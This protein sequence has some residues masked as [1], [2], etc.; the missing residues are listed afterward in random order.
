MRM[1][2]PHLD[3]SPPLKK[4]IR[5]SKTRQIRGQKNLVKM[6]T[7][8]FATQT[9]FFCY[10]GHNDPLG[11]SDRQQN[12]DNQL[13]FFQ[14][15]DTLPKYQSITSR[16]DCEVDEL[17]SCSSCFLVG[18]FFFSVIWFFHFF[19]WSVCLINLLFCFL[20]TFSITFYTKAFRLSKIIAWRQIKRFSLWQLLKGFSDALTADKLK[21]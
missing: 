15:T 9:F 6:H 8:L 5:H 21:T 17:I 2:V 14:F 4:D 13:T 16:G 19:F 3:S 11:P 20:L 18:L 1:A 10:Q 12:N 7:T